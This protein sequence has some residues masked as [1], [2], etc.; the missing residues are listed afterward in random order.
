MEHVQVLVKGHAEENVTQ[1]VTMV[2]RMVVRQDV[3]ELVVAVVRP[4]AMVNRVW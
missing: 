2:V 4:H 1:H 3:K